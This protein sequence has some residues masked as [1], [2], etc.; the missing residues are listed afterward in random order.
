MVAHGAVLSPM[1]H[2]NVTP[3]LSVASLSFLRGFAVIA[4]LRSVERAQQR[5]RARAPESVWVRP[6]STYY[7]RARVRV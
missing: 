6:R 7:T 3:P 5:S 4:W 2:T 1:A